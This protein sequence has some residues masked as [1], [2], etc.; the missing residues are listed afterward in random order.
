MRGQGGF[1]LLEVL[2]ALTILG[3]GAVA[4]I[5]LSAQGLRLVKQSDDHQGAILLADRLAKETAPLAEGLESGNEGALE[6]ERRIARVATPEALHPPSGPTP[7][8]LALTV[9]VRWGRDA[10]LTLATLRTAPAR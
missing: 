7:R 4:L 6:W 1:T 9:T 2:V 5:Q 8:L 3:L 10:A